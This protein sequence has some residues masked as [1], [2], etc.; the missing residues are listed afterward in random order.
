MKPNR[1]PVWIPGNIPDEEFSDDTFTPE[2]D[3]AELA[4]RRRKFIA[5]SMRKKRK[6]PDESATV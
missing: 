3:E 5:D 1:L 2:A 4:V 6:R